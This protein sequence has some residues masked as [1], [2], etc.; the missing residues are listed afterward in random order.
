[1]QTAIVEDARAWTAT[2]IDDRRAWYYPLSDACR[3]AVERTLREFR[4]DS[5]PVTDATLPPAAAA[6][7]AEC[8][9]P[10][11]A[12]L[13]E[14]RGF[15]ILSGVPVERYSVREA[16]LFYWRIGQALG[17]PFEQN[18]QGTLLY[19]VRDT[20]QYV[21]Q[22]ARFSVTN[23]ESSFHTDNSFGQEVADYVGLLCVRAAKSGGV[24]MIVSGYTAH[25]ELLRSHPDVLPALYEPFHVDRR[26]GVP[27][28]ES[29]T[30]SVPIFQWDE[31]GLTCRY[32]RY[33]IEVGHQ[34]AGRPLS[35]ARTRALD[36]LDGVLNRPELMATF[37]L[38]A[39]QILLVNNRWTFHNRTA[40]EDHAEAER[41]RH[42][43]RLWLRAP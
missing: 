17:R 36:T 25:N 26:G 27:E 14:G 24:N 28:G 40:F 30:I 33:W 3:G 37:A 8:L 5:R 21:S 10:V 4:D 34:K 43:V 29:P 11:R 1:L 13:D 31:A 2:S 32:L 35:P 7:C 12:A 6:A 22:G 38:E 41:R 15:A 23:A 16:Q 39:G 19:D 9:R 18:V 42:L 20:G